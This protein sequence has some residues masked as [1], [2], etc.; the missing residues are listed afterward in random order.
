MF[1][2]T[3]A[4]YKHFNIDIA[5]FWLAFA[6]F[7]KLKAIKAP[8]WESYFQFRTHQRPHIPRITQLLKSATRFTMTS[9]ASGRSSRIPVDQSANSHMYD[10]TVADIEG[11][12]QHLV[13]QFPCQAPKSDPYTIV[14]EVPTSTVMSVIEPEFLRLFQNLQL[15]EFLDKVEDFL[16]DH[17]GSFVPCQPKI[18]FQQKKSA[19]TWGTS[20]LVIMT[21][22]SL[23]QTAS[24]ALKLKLNANKRP[25]TATPE[26]LHSN[27]AE[28]PQRFVSKNVFQTPRAHSKSSEC[29]ELRRIFENLAKSESKMMQQYIGDLI[30]SLE[31][32]SIVEQCEERRFDGTVSTLEMI[33]TCKAIESR[34]QDSLHCLRKVLAANHGRVLDWL[35]RGMLTPCMSP[36]GL[37]EQLRSHTGAAQAYTLKRML[38]EYGIAI[39]QHQ[40]LLRITDAYLKNNTRKVSEETKNNGHG[41]WSPIEH[42][43]WLLIELDGNLLIR[44]EQV[45]VA[46]ATISP[47]TGQNS[48]LQMNMGKVRFRRSIIILCSY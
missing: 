25:H 28:L 12:A 11:F 10:P 29:E 42:P 8:T 14:A 30:Q 24:A 6:F 31:A 43:D 41:N 7:D 34:V 13:R 22:H 23:F 18:A 1:V 40:R 26:P 46:L 21:I 47:G 45:T 35:T 5:M 17:H 27:L 37:L 19:I 9:F 4:V 3:L 36:T 20:R 15:S 44:N 38:V 32:F 39:A 33:S 2:I 48:L 16:Q